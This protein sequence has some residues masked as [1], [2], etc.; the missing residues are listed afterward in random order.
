MFIKTTLEKPAELTDS[1]FA[2]VL[3]TKSC[4][5]VNICRLLPIVATCKAHMENI[6]KTAE[7]TLAPFF[8]DIPHSYSIN[9]KIRNNNSLSRNLLLPQLGDIMKSL[10][11]DNRVDLTNPDFVISIEVITNICCVG[12]MKKF[13]EYRKYNLQELACKINE[14]KLNPEKDV[15]NSTGSTGAQPV[16]SPGDNPDGETKDH[17]DGVQADTNDNTATETN[18][19]TRD[20]SNT[21]DDNTPC[22]ASSATID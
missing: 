8:Q 13:S 9:I 12:V 16:L 22:H 10:N 11:C 5:S 6:L 1:L 17:D 4:P 2:D 18:A 19:D 14:E 15:Q 7:K 3:Q 20:E 21:N